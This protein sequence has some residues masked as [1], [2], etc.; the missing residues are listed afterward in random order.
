MTLPLWGSWHGAAVTEEAI[1]ADAAGNSPCRC[2][3]LP[4]H[5]CGGQ[6][7]SFR[8]TFQPGND[9]RPSFARKSAGF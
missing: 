4:L 1:P 9:F 5:K 6:G 2:V 7:L 3:A 8:C